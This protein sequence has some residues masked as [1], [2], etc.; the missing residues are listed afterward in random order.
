VS[1]QKSVL[2]R[3]FVN[4][5]ASSTR[6]AKALQADTNFRMEHAVNIALLCVPGWDK[7]EH[8]PNTILELINP[9][10]VVLSHYDDFGSPYKNGEDPTIPGEMQFVPFANYGRFLTRLKE[11]K[12][13]HNYHYD[14]DEPKTG[15]CIRF[16]GSNQV[17]SCER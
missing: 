14:I 11:L 8:Y 17:V 13:K 3:V 9:D 10:K 15:Q 12:T 6:G 4:G 7:V 5:A 2:W 16:P 1:L